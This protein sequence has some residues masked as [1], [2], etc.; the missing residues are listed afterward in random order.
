MTPLV[1]LAVNTF[2]RSYRS[3]LAPGFFPQIEAQHRYRFASRIAVINNVESRADAKA[4]AE[5]LVRRGEIDHF[6]FVADHLERA[7]E[8]VG[9]TR[10][11]LGR[12]PYYTDWAIV[13][14]CLRGS[15]WLLCWDAD[16]R[17]REPA[18]WIEPAI[19][20]MERDLRIMTANPNWQSGTLERETI[21]TSDGFA[22]GYGFSDQAFLVRRADLARP[23]YRERCVA[24]LRYPLSH[25]APIFEQ[26]VDAYMRTHRRLRATFREAVYIHP[27]EGVSY[28]AL[29]LT[30][31]A[32]RILNRALLVGRRMIPSRD[33]AQRA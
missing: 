32:Q 27:G 13:A 1:D 4:H 16:I 6:E 3:V 21:E 17:M 28:P 11:D 19:A 24:S 5:D 29:T 10:R 18:N 25:I 22:L 26:R 31:T 7:L 20:L 8:H 14:V 2:E 9:L 23:I 30:E 15:P 12:I 33:P